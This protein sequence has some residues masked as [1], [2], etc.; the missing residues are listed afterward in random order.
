MSVKL[1]GHSEFEA[2]S[3]TLRAPTDSKSLTA[4]ASS[5]PRTRA[6]A[7]ERSLPRWTGAHPG[8]G[9][10]AW[11]T[12]GRLTSPS[13]TSTDKECLSL[14]HARTPRYQFHALVLELGTLCQ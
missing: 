14:L 2:H 12:S 11:R 3:A 10:T 4:S 8:A 7:C 9:N 1:H 13:W 5:S 6:A